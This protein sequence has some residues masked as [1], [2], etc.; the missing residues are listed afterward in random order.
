MA[1]PSIEMGSRRDVRLE[2]LLNQD[3][4]TPDNAADAAIAGKA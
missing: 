2:G 1:Q 3:L 4:I